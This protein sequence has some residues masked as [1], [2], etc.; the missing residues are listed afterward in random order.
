MM[1]V[2]SRVPLTSLIERSQICIDE[3]RLQQQIFRR[4]AGQR[5][6]RKRDDIGVC[7]ART[8]HPFKNFW[9]FPSMSPTTTFICAIAKRN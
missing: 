6:L 1:A 2:I 3:L 8:I 4:I 9:A 7:I 5:Q